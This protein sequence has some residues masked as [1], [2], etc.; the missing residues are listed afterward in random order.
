[1]SFSGEALSYFMSSVY[2]ITGAVMGATPGGEFLAGMEAAREVGAQASGRGQ[3]RCLA[4][5]AS[6]LRAAPL[7]RAADIPV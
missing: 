3:P 2:T 1:M 5:P 4:C 6:G 7:S